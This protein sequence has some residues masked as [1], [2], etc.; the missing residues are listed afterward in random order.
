M[1]PL[2]C[3]WIRWLT[4]AG[5]TCQLLNCSQRG[6]GSDMSSLT[7]RA[8]IVTTQPAV[9]VVV[10]APLTT[11]VWKGGAMYCSAI[12][13]LGLE[14]RGNRSSNSVGGHGTSPHASGSPLVPLRMLL[15]AFT[16]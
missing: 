10:A 12:D 2:R 15:A 9:A 7:M 1:P 6:L 3:H 4:G 5:P 14:G 11:W 16:W 13:D 8:P